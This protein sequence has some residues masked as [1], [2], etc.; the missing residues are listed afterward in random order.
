ML[1]QEIATETEFA[2][3]KSTS[4]AS[5]QS[6][7]NFNFVHRGSVGMKGKAKMVKPEVSQPDMDFGDDSLLD[8]PLE[9]DNLDAHF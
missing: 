4:A 5:E 9:M 2:D 8:E 6:S 3:E 7:T 1:D